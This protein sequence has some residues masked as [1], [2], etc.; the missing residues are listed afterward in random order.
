MADVPV[1]LNNNGEIF[2]MAIIVGL[3]ESRITCSP[4]AQ[5]DKVE[6]ISLAAGSRCI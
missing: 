5:D 4:V 1:E 6:T 2:D 3:I